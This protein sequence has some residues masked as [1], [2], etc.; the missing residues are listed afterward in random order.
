MDYTSDSSC[1]ERGNKFRGVG[2]KS[3]GEYRV[4]STFDQW[5]PVFLVGHSTEEVAVGTIL[6]RFPTLY[7]YSWAGTFGTRHEMERY[8]KNSSTQLLVE[9]RLDPQN[10]I[11]S[12]ACTLL[13]SSY[14]FTMK[15]L[16]HNN[17]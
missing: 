10:K 12:L 8:L 3:P 4:L 6:T 11:Q 15:L 5:Y 2:F 9:I 7:K 1:L 14:D 13:V 16:I 17:E